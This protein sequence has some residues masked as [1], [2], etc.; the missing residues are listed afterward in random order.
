VAPGTPGNPAEQI[1]E[2]IL[3]KYG[4]IEKFGGKPL[5]ELY[6]PTFLTRQFDVL[7][8]NPPWLSFRY[9]EKGEY[10]E[11]LK[12]LI[13]SDYGLPVQLLPAALQR[14]APRWYVVLY[15]MSATYLCAA[16]APK[17]GIDCRCRAKGSAASVDCRPCELLL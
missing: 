5:E 4:S 9:I 12:L 2:N 14:K 7:M 10:Q 8:G 6:K 3:K 15:P 16:V 17:K 13:V 11:Y 1:A